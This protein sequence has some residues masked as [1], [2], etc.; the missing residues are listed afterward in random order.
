MTTYNTGNPI[1]STDARDRLDNSENLDLAVN[2]LSPTFVDRLG[3]T[4]DTLEGIYQKSAYYRAGTFD[5][6]YTLT[7]N[8]QTLA[9][10]NVEYSWSGAFPKVVPSASKPETSGG[11]GDG[12]WVDRTQE[13]LRS[14]LASPGGVKLV[15]GVGFLCA[16][17]YAGEND[18]EI[19]QNAI[20]DAIAKKIAF[21]TFN[22]DYI[23]SSEIINRQEVIF[24]GTHEIT[25]AGSYRMRIVRGDEKTMPVLDGVTAAQLP[26]FSS[27]LNPVVVVVGDSITTQQPNSVDAVNTQYQIICNK[28]K[29]DNPG[30]SIT[31]YNRG[32][33]GM[34][35]FQLDGVASSGWPDWYT[36]TTDPWL[37][38]VS[39]LN[40]DLVIVS[41][42]MND[43][44][45]NISLNAV[46]SVIAKI[47]AMSSKPDVVMVTCAVPSTN[48]G[49]SFHAEY[50]SKSGQE[51]RDYA[52]GVVRAA[53]VKN[54]VPF[55]DVNRVFNV[56]RDGFDV[57]DS[58]SKII[59][60]ASV[61]G[62]GYLS[63]VECRNWS[64]VVGLS[65]RAAYTG[66]DPIAVKVGPKST[67]VCFI[68]INGIFQLQI[69]CYNAQQGY[70]TTYTLADQIV[71]DSAHQLQIEVF[72][73][74]IRVFVVG[75]TVD[76]KPDFKNLYVGGGLYFPGIGKYDANYGSGTLSS[77]DQFAYGE[78][79]R[80][81]PS[82]KNTELW[83]AGDNSGATKSPYGG[84][85][86]NHPSSIGAQAVWGMALSACDFSCQVNGIFTHGQ[87][88]G[89]E[90][91]NGKIV[92]VWGR[93]LAETVGARVDAH[94]TWPVGVPGAGYVLTV[95]GGVNAADLD[96]SMR[97]AQTLINI[98]TPTSEGVDITWHCL[99]DDTLG[100]FADWTLTL[101]YQ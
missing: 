6:G 51:G 79:T 35:F 40:P 5:A 100:R 28:I 4:R 86:I 78:H 26:S 76:S 52:A 38:Y 36:T 87:N 67:E 56:V 32:I 61:S 88:G 74:G 47:R 68:K 42:G 18:S 7:N 20:N 25:G 44:S 37:D 14:D 97:T 63:P 23:V 99:T 101:V 53:S 34:G 46:E 45:E 92:R 10:G 55:I 24:V 80:Y 2:S 98:S 33:G 75:S 13:S 70:Y 82:V 83:G 60:G 66:A 57:L 73:Q 39:A 59:A 58:H 50:G 29:K 41:M 94:I 9:Y 64:A 22:R 16:E 95:S 71:P 96:P 69:E 72:N 1:G 21:V 15:S 8:R 48:P 84:N 91:K 49:Q 81:M 85:G 90:I 65:G 77:V 30:R 3:V 31:F 54:A 19:L 12:A 62:G 43:S 17:S 27:K 89:Y 93:K 11:I